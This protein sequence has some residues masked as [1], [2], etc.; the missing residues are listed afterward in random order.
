MQK[1]QSINFYEEKKL[2]RAPVYQHL[3]DTV[4]GFPGKYIPNN[5]SHG[6]IAFM[7]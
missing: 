2:Y 1:F 5:M 6:F 3:K 7:V 4:L